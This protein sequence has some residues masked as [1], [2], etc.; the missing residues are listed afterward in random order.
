MM[1]KMPVANQKGNDFT[2]T[3][4]EVNDGLTREPG[5]YGTGSSQYSAADRVNNRST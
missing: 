4:Y 1:Q 5:F 3:N 2:V